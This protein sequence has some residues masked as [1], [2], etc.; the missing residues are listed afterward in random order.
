MTKPTTKEGLEAAITR[1]KD[2]T[3]P[4]RK[5]LLVV[6]DNAA[7]RMSITELLGHDDIDITSVGTGGEAL[8]RLRAEP[9]D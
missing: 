8:E 2:Y 6:E 3:Q 5:R 7:E 4:R 1:I 9:I